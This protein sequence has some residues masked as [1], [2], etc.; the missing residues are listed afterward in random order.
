[1]IDITHKSNSLRMATAQAIVHVSSE[2]T[3]EAVKNKTIPKGDVLE[4]ARAAGLFAVK[5]TSDVIPDCHP[6]PIESTSISY[7]ISGMEI[8]ILIEVK[9]I[10]KTG[11][12]VEAMHGASII[13]LTIYDMLKPIDKGIE[14]HSIKLLEKSGGKSDYKNIIKRELTS[15]VIVCSDSISNGEKTDKS[16]KYITE[17]LADLGIHIKEFDIIPD[18]QDQIREKAIQYANAGIDLI[19]FTGGT[20]LSSRDKSPE[21]V[22]SVVDREIPGIMEI[23]RSY[24]QERMPFSMLSRGVAGLKGHSLILTFP[25]S[26]NAVRDYL[27]ALFP[28]VLHLFNVMEG[29]GHG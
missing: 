26:V 22:L 18:D 7:E 4:I 6:L 29:E 25:G 27:N 12:E 10:Y 2:K 20:G 14:I 15:A 19:L 1:M 13:A 28:F 21:A 3:I 9:T 8:K 23:A 16:G 17:K 5:K 24:G 11:V